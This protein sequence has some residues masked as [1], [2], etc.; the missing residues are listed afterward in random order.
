MEFALFHVDLSNNQESEV[1]HLLHAR[2]TDEEIETQIMVLTSSLNGGGGWG[3]ILA[4]RKERVC[5]WSHRWLGAKPGL[6]L[7]VP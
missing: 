4:Q 5:T 6:E 3:E 2:C 7:L 1:R